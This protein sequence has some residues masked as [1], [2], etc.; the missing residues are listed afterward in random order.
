MRGLPSIALFAG[1]LLVGCYGESDYSGDGRL[2]DHGLLSATDR[3]VLELGSLPLTTQ[4]AKTYRIESLPSRRFVIGIELR[5]SLNSGGVLED[6]PVDAVLAVELKNSKG[7]T[8]VRR[9][10]KLREWTWSVHSPGDYAFIYG[11]GKENTFF[12]PTNAE[13]YELKVEIG[14]PDPNASHYSPKLVAKSGGWK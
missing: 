9:K 6:R 4:G 10:G 2:V 13:R 14:V 1:T 11:E 3:Y 5:K 7:E 12:I 8:L